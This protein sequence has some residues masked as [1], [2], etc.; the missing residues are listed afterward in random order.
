MLVYVKNKLSARS[1]T[2][3]GVRFG[4]NFDKFNMC[5]VRIN[6]RLNGA[7]CYELIEILLWDILG[8]GRI[9][10]LDK[11]FIVR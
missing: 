10:F 11:L 7:C 8:L 1:V 4:S 9:C 6:E 2:D 3:E 5:F